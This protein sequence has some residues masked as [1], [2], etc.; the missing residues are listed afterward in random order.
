MKKNNL[1]FNN[2]KIAFNYKSNF[3]LKRAYFLFKLLSLGY[4]SKFG[5]KL[6]KTLVWMNFPIDFIIKKT[7][8]AQFC[9]GTDILDSVGVINNLKKSNV[10]SILDYSIEGSVNENDF[11]DSI[12]KCL[13]ILEISILFYVHIF[14]KNQTFSKIVQYVLINFQTVSIRL[15]V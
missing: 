6:L 14:N 8:Y 2:T 12:N 5:R 3:D 11:E 1:E 9:G 4:I 15:Y 10:Y 7:I 13:K